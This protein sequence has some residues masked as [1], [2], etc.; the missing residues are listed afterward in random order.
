[1][2]IRAPKPIKLKEY[3]C[4][5][6][7]WGE[8]SLMPHQIPYYS[9]CYPAKSSSQ[10]KPRQHCICTDGGSADIVSSGGEVRYT[11]TARFSSSYSV[12]CAQN[13]LTLL[14]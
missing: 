5:N 12:E 2:F 9:T 7:H 8:I 3:A 10:N 6:V 4:T 13:K 1:M 11:F 14:R